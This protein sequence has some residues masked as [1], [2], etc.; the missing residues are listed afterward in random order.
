MGDYC[1]HV[2]S[3]FSVLF[4]SGPMLAATFLQTAVCLDRRQSI[5]DPMSYK[6][7]DHKK[8]AL[9]ATGT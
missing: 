9:L 7:L 3:K 1:R 5:T 8:R 6:L 4:V 2:L